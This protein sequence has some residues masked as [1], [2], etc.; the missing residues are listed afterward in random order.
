MSGLRRLVSGLSAQR[1][2]FKPKLVHVRIWW[3]KCHGESI[4]S[5]YFCFSLSVS[6]HRFSFLIFIYMLLLP[7][8]QTV[9]IVDLSKNN[10]PSEIGVHEIDN[11]L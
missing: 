4:F 5:E 2:G 6:F 1:P 8:G 10:V 9:K 3:K 7:E 11:K